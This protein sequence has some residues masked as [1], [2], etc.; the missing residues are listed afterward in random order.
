MAGVPGR[1]RTG[2]GG[3]IHAVIRQAGDGQRDIIDFSAN[4][5]PLGAPDWLRPLVSRE[6][7]NLQHYPDPEYPEFIAA[8]AEV[9]GVDQA[10]VVPGNGSTELLYVLPRILPCRRALIPVPSYSDYRRACSLAGLA[11]EL[12]SLNEADDFRLDLVQ[13]AA[14]IEDGDLIILAS[15]NNPTGSLLAASEIIAL[16]EAFP[17]NFFLIDE[18]FLDFID[19]AISVAG[20]AANIL[21]LHSMT[22][23]YA[24]PGLRLGYGI[25]PAPIAEQMRAAMPPWTI[26]QL[27]QAVGCRALS[28]HLYQEQSRALCR[29]L[30]Q[31]LHTELAAFPTLKVYAGAA[32]YLLLRLPVGESVLDL[33]GRMLAEGILIRC[34]DNYPGLDQR[35]FRLAVR[36]E[37]ENDRLLQA[38]AKVLGVPP[39]REKSLRRSAKTPALMFQGTSSNAGKSILTAALCRI[40]L[41]DGVRVAPFKAQNMSLNSGVTRLGEEMGRAQVVQAQAAKIDADVRMNP[42]LLK[43]NSDTGSQI[44]VCGH[45]VGNMSVDK[46]TS[47]KPEAWP[48]VCRCYDSLADEYQAIILEGAGSPG[49]VNLKHDDLVN[50]KMARYAKA[51]VLLVGDI[52]RGGVY[53]SFVGTMEVLAEWERRLVA[54]FVVN[55][56]RGQASLLASAHRYLREH[57]DRE[58]FGVVP[59]IHN[60]GL[61][62]EDSVSFKA[63][64]FNRPQLD[65]SGIVIAVV[66]LPHIAN[67]TDIEPFLA[68]PDVHIR[69]VDQPGQLDEADLIL[70]PGSKNVMGDLAYLDDKGFSAAIRR[71]AE[72]GVAIVGICGGYQILGRFVADPHHLESAADR[73]P[74][75]GLLD[76]STE[77]AADKTLVRR[78]GVHIPSGLAIRGY[79]IHHGISTSTL[80]PVLRFSDGASCG[81][82]KG[83]AIWGS[84]LHGIFDDDGFRR[85]FIDDLRRTKG[86]API[87]EIVAPYDLEIAF[88]RLADQVRASLDMARIHALLGL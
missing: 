85:W 36:T 80:P 18:A 28:D 21:T 69:I 40:L 26:N 82:T 10:M 68:E 42:I 53:A 1:N 35:Y 78:Q 75:L 14:R 48:Q 29:E 86:L 81:A 46:Y 25:F 24:I 77:L 33:A 22:K 49:E 74:G 3:T 5:N 34:C 23:F 50:M 84:Y 66:N 32:N 88:D 15:P 62:E 8:L 12:F 79:E 58:V 61:P 71:R 56:F 9:H 39:R 63:G 51:P 72:A 73:R 64:S 60:L 83:G 41:Q 55:R 11:V 87:G 7:T 20:R 4:I 2:H 44:I 67:F 65:P 17:N 37:E 16:A 13:L 31:A 30:R 70:L 76:L 27:A 43:P 54:G 6:L 57:C 47:Y 19:G 38:L 45:P 52:D 59:Y